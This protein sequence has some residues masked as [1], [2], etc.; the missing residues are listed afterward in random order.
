M[1]TA[2]IGWAMVFVPA[3]ICMGIFCGWVTLMWTVLGIIGFVFAC[4]YI[5]FAAILVSGIGK[6]EDK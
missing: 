1:K 6:K 4:A 2:W 3:A 5:E